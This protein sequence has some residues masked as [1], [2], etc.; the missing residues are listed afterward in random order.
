MGKG[1]G[2]SHRPAPSR[3]PIQGLRG[4]GAHSGEELRLWFRAGIHRKKQHADHPRIWVLPVPG[5]NSYHRGYPIFT[6]AEAVKNQ[7]GTCTRCLDACPT[8][9]LESALQAECVQVPFVSHHRKKRRGR[10][11]NGEE[12]WGDAFSDATGVRKPAR[13]PG[14]RTSGDHPSFPQIH[15]PNANSGF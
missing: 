3:R 12:E 2:R 6:K 4:F 13:K 10:Q 1:P 7:C 9:A 5:G 14:K 11:G 15:P 8:G